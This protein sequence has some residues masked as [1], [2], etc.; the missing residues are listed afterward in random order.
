MERLRV[1]WTS[2]SAGGVG[3]GD[4]R[5]APELTA[6]IQHEKVKALLKANDLLRKQLLQ[7]DKEGKDNVRV[8]RIKK[9]ETEVEEKQVRLPC[10]LSVGSTLALCRPSV[11]GVLVPH[12]CAVLPDCV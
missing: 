7:K 5:I 4:E 11:S 9:L 1:T 2:S 10:L 12:V 6:K 8:K 3:T